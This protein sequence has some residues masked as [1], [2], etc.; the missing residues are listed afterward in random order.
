M[1][2]VM[3][4]AALA[5]AAAADANAADEPEIVASPELVVTAGRN[6]QTFDY[7]DGLKVLQRFERL[8]E[9]QRSHVQLRFY[10]EPTRNHKL[11]QPIE[12]LEMALDA[13][14]QVLPIDVAPSGEIRLPYLVPRLARAAVLVSTQPR[15]S[16]KVVYKVDLA[17]P[18]HE[19]LTAAWLRTAIAQAKPAWRAVLPRMARKTVP[20]FDCA[21]F[22]VLGLTAVSFEEPSL[23]TAWRASAT[24]D[25]PAKWPQTSDVSD[26]AQLTLSGGPLRRVA[27][28]R[29]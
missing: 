4:F 9:E 10:V 3:L 6:P 29:H 16:L 23:R 22:Q 28:C 13:G 5:L 26:A 11:A 25:S 2:W 7:A 15:G 18:Q 27:V 20:T 17:V 24:P 1:Q 8:P 12:T 19:P 21:E 14:D